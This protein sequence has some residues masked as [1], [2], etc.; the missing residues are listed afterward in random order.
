MRKQREKLYV[1]YD[2]TCNL[3]IG[4]VTKLKELRSNAELIF[5]PAQSLKEA[6]VKVPGIEKVAETELY[7]KM[8]V[9]D[10]KGQLYAGADGVVRILRTI[11][12]FRLLAMLYRLPGLSR[13]GDLVYRYIAKRRYDWFGRTEQSC[14]V[15]GCALPPQHER[16]KGNH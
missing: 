6:G 4:T 9:A 12:G 13:V 15:N 3:C 11:N 16:G 1:V 8:H 14:S 7:E 10:E 2:G 5:V